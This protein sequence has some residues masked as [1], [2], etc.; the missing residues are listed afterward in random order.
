MPR[1]REQRVGAGSSVSRQSKCGAGH[2]GDR[3]HH[4]PRRVACAVS[5]DTAV[6][7]AVLSVTRRKDE[8]N[9]RTGVSPIGHDCAVS[10]TRHATTSPADA[11]SCSATATADRTVALLTCASA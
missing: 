2:A 3:D 6:L 11:S 5:G 1:H 8:D 10:H 4:R 9:F 7:A